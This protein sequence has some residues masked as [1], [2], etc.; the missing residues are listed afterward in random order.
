MAICAFSEKK[1]EEELAQ[2]YNVLLHEGITTFKAKQSKASLPT[3]VTAEKK[4]RI[5][6]KG[7]VFVVRDKAHFTANGVRGYIVTSK[8]T[9]LED[10]QA[11]TH[12]TPNVYRT[13]GYT[14]ENRRYIRGFE[15]RN[16]Q[17][18]NTFVVDIDTKK[19]TENELLL[20]C[21]DESI[22][23]PTLIVESTRGYQ[24][25][26]ALQQPFF[27][28]PKND[29][30][31]LKVAKRISDNLKQS[32]QAVEADI[33][34]NDFGFFRL[35]NATNIVY[36]GLDNVYAVGSLIDW[37]MRQDDNKDRPL[38]VLAAKR[39]ASSVLESEWFDALVHT[40]NING[41]KGKLGRNNTLF[42][43]ALIGYS[44]GWDIERT[45]NFLDE[46][47]ARLEAPLNASDLHTI[48]QSAYSGK[49]HGPSKEYVEALLA[50]HVKNG[51]SYKVSL[52]HRCWYKFKKA[53]EDRQRSHYD[54]W[55]ADI[56]EYI[57]AQKRTTE[58]FIWLTQK[59]MCEAIGIPQS[60]LNVLL[61]NSSKLIKTVT[62]KGRTSKTGWT[63][64]QLFITYTLNLLRAQKNT[65]TTYVHEII[66]IHVNA[67]EP[68]AGYNE[69][70]QKLSLLKVLP[71]KHSSTFSWL[72]SSG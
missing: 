56:T 52:G 67:L 14:D 17:Q 15:E 61:K 42:T 20:T 22:G 62:G 35:P 3:R 25:Y 46:F 12:F 59:E 23:L 60:T 39:L 53:R 33:F 51:E 16:L 19:Y 31:G 70:I 38:F 28:S 43:L 69:L 45:E 2:I 57:T 7:A 24:L 5:H 34:C 26:F 58:P 63:T 9:L 4:D 49:Y 40:V 65:Y 48:L 30:R 13:F 36:E 71:D 6:K 47:N 21:M 64:V 66:Q 18:I 8:E 27:I 37:S 50:L 11:L 44:E 72:D 54:E 41:D 29:F 1:S 10:A 68:I 32:L 55:E